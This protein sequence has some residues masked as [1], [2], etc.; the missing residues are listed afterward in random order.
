M[1]LFERKLLLVFRLNP[2]VTNTRRGTGDMRKRTK[3]ETVQR[4]RR[5]KASG[6][7]WPVPCL[8]GDR[9]G[10]G[11]PR[12]PP[13]G[14]CVWEG[15]KVVLMTP[16]THTSSPWGSWI[17]VWV[18]VVG[19]DRGLP[20]L[21]VSPSLGLHD[22]SLTQWIF[23]SKL[24][25]KQCFLESTAEDRG[26]KKKYFSGQSVGTVNR[27]WLRLKSIAKR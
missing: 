17:K 8:H 9:R 21:C 13:W 25:S 14:S 6:T 10:P 5:R 7:S 2:P 11:A 24:T 12:C 20:N 19:L 22:I 23:S 16:S 1:S 15:L 26:V 4:R 3:G 18:K 27:N